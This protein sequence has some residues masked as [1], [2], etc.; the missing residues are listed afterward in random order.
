MAASHKGRITSSAHQSG[1]CATDKS[2]ACQ[3]RKLFR[4]FD[5]FSKDSHYRKTRISPGTLAAPWYLNTVIPGTRTVQLCLCPSG[6]CAALL[7]LPAW[8]AKLHSNTKFGK[9][10]D[11]LY[12][13]NGITAEIA[14][15]V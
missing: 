14:S 15:D 10:V 11:Y 6:M 8:E 4:Q 13:V 9:A 12:S 1:K 7:Q 3:I 2:V 5:S